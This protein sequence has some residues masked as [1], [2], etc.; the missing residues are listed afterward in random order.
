MRLREFK[1]LKK[2]HGKFSTRNLSYAPSDDSS[3]TF[4]DDNSDCPSDGASDE[5]NS[6]SDPTWDWSKSDEGLLE[7]IQKLK[8][9]I[10]GDNEG[11]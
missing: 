10:K 9:N 8:L 11:F 3:D 2:Q 6:Y 1:A 7:R 5:K 4:S